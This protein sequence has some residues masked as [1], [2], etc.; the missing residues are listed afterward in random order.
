LHLDPDVEDCANAT[1]ACDRHLIDLTALDPRHGGARDGR[2]VR[3]ISLSPAAANSAHPDDATEAEVVHRSSLV[4]GAYAWLRRVGPN[5]TCVRYDGPADAAVDALVENS[6]VVVDNR[7]WVVDRQ[8]ANVDQRLASV[9]GAWT[10]EVT[11]S[12]RCSD[13]V[14]LQTT[15]CSVLGL[16]R[17]VARAYI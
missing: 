16:T 5:R 7:T 15:R 9:R 10:A 1:N 2:S 13:R 11:N 17:A 3:Q 12:T 14:R 4:D 8:G 6:A